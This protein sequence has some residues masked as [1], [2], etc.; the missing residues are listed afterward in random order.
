MMRF[1][2]GLADEV[3]QST[4]GPHDE[5]WLN[6]LDAT[7]PHTQ[8][9][10]EYVLGHPDLKE[11][12]GGRILDL[13]AGTCWLTARLSR[14]DKVEGVAALHLSRRF[15]RSV[16]ERMIRR[17]EGDDN[18]ITFAVSSFNRVPFPSTEFDCV[19]LV[20]AI[21]HSLTPIK[22]LME[23]HRLLRPGGVLFVVESPNPVIGLESART[24]AIRLSRETGIIEICY[25]RREY[26][27]MLRQAGFDDVRCYPVDTVTRGVLRQAGRMLL[28]TL[29][30]EDAFRPPTYVF[31]A[32]R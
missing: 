14:L 22:T 18:K 10:I 7:Q 20:A 31:V 1:E 5:P 27:Y 2:S 4:A 6:F 12:I 3:A 32:T 24:E 9:A 25:T 29:G 26:E 28:R 23:A 19:F 17:F 11:R 16:G 15:L 8:P 30:L 21:R 13:A